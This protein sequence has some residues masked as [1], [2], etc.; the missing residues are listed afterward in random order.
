MKTPLQIEL[1]KNI[2]ASAVEKRSGGGGKELSYLTGAYVINRLNEVLGQGNW[3]Y[4]IKALTKTFEGTVVQG[5]KKESVF[6]V[7]Y[8]AQL[9]FEANIDGKRAFFEEIGYGDGTDKSS[10][11]KAHELA[12]KEA[13][14][15]SLKRAA[16]NLGISFGL[17]LYFKSEEYVD[18][19]DLQVKSETRDEAKKV[20]DTPVPP[21]GT[22]VDLTEYLSTKPTVASE[23]SGKQLKAAIQEVRAGI[24]TKILR[25]KIKSAFS[26]L[27]SRK[28]ITKEEFVKTYL[29]GG[30]VDTLTDD[31]VMKTIENL[32]TNFKELS[33]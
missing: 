3:G 9:F 28:K 26:F 17:G 1:D 31:Q 25:T 15:D 23:M 6:A 10:P 24:D 2:P 19:Q 18:E 5:Y 33:L 21:T 12:T 4:T 11:G 27:E 22:K 32:K 8:I 29:E 13:I 16:K 14:T 20:L 7:S 30:K